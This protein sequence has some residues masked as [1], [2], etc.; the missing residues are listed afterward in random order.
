MLTGELDDD[1]HADCKH[2]EDARAPHHE[3]RRDSESAKDACDGGS[4]KDSPV[5]ILDVGSGGLFDIRRLHR[6]KEA[7]ESQRTEERLRGL[8]IGRPDDCPRKELA[9]DEGEEYRDK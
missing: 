9:I 6:V 5:S 2:D 7:D 3:V 4:T 1:K 8:V